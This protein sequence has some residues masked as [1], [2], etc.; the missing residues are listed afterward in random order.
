VLGASVVQKLSCELGVNSESKDIT[1]LQDNQAIVVDVHL[2]SRS[3]GMDHQHVSVQ[4]P[5]H[6]CCVGFL[7]GIS[8]GRH[9]D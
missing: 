4:W 5:N 7:E 6:A 8:R 9:Y 1:Y 3:S 2:K